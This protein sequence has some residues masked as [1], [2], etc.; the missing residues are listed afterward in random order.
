[1][2]PVCHIYMCHVHHVGG[3]VAPA[4]KRFRR[5][6]L[7]QMERCSGAPTER[8]DSPVEMVLKV[9]HGA[10]GPFL[11]CDGASVDA[12]AR[13]QVLTTQ[14]YLKEVGSDNASVPACQSRHAR[15]PPYPTEVKPANP[16]WHGAGPFYRPGA[17]AV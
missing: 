5:C 12:G 10:P 14:V 6:R 2:R 16:P 13:R 8:H 1:M 4:A 7:V 11:K 17:R 9:E 3:Y 15:V